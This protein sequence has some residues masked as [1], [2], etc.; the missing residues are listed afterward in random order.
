[1][2]EENF[3]ENYFTKN[4]VYLFDMV[5]QCFLIL[6]IK[7]WAINYN[8]W[9]THSCHLQVSWCHKDWIHTSWYLIYHIYTLIYIEQLPQILMTST[10]DPSPLVLL[11][12][13]HEWFSLHNNEASTDTSWNYNL[14]HSQH[15]HNATS[16]EHLTFYADFII[17]LVLFY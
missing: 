11:L 2:F 13:P 16:L 1:M 15:V 4:I 5:L 14:I 8:V 12:K 6:W 9:I 7:V 17:G 3:W 10:T